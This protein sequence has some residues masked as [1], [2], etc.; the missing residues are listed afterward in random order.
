MDG[1]FFRIK[2]SHTELHFQVKYRNYL[3]FLIDYRNF[4]TSLSILHSNNY[5]I[6]NFGSLPSFQWLVSY[7]FIVCL[8]W[9]ARIY[10]RDSPVY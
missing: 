9:A 3:W 2:H 1:E 10:Q 5:S 8:L 6:H 7:L 4:Y